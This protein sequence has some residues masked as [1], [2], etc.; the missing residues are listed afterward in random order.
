MYTFWTVWRY[1]FIHGTINTAKVPNILFV[2]SKIFLMF[3]SVFYFN[4]Y[5]LFRTLESYPLNIF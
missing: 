2:T 5:V 4:F 1:S 3:F